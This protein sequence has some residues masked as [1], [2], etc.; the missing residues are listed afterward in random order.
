[1][2][3]SQALKKIKF[4]ISCRYDS[5]STLFEARVFFVVQENE[6]SQR[7]KTNVGQLARST[8]T[9]IQWYRRHEWRLTDEEK[10]VGLCDDTTNGINILQRAI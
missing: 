5:S 8:V 4:L 9:H 6:T 1:M 3:I 7:G 2:Q 10:G